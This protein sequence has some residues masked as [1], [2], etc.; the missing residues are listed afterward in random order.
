MN[1]ELEIIKKIFS[2]SDDYVFILNHSFEILWNNKEDCP[3]FFNTQAL[4]QIAEERK[5]SLESGD[6]PIYYNG[7]EFS[8]KLINYSEAGLYVIQMNG[9]DII[10]S[11]MRHKSVRNFLSNQEAQIRE[12]IVGIAFAGDKLRKQLDE[13]G[14]KEGE[15][16]ADIATGNCYKLLR[17]FLGTNELI[18]YRE[19]PTEPVKIELSS[20]LEGFA[21]ICARVVNGRIKFNCRVASHELYIKADAERLTTCLLELMLLTCRNS[22]TTESVTISADKINDSISLTFFSD[23]VKEEP[24]RSMFSK[25][26]KLYKDSASDP[27][28]VVINKFC[29]QFGASLFVADI[30]EKESKSYSLCFP[31]CYDDGIIVKSP[32]TSVTTDRFSKFHIALSEISEPI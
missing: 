7:L 19:E 3:N 15:R 11:I 13:C 10:S 29:T 2:H 12:S 28:L 5:T 27:D 17:A 26:E 20:M 1:N 6:Y 31:V 9:D 8:V 32:K 25:L 21:D 24:V 23:C 18:K 14:L 22:K 16:F 4:S 30:P